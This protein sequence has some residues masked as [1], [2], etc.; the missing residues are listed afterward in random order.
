MQN[1]K[2][3]TGLLL[4]GLWFKCTP[5]TPSSVAIDQTLAKTSRPVVHVGADQLDLL[6][7]KLTGKNIGLV[8]NHTAAVGKTHLTDTLESQGVI[9]KKIFA[10]EHG[11]RGSAADGETIKDGVDIKTGL[12]VISLYGANKKPTREQL[13]DIDVVVFDIQ[14]VGARFYTFISTLH[15]VME[16]CAEQ[17]KK[18]ILLDRPNP[19]GH[20]V[21]GPVLDTALRSFVGMH[22]IPIVHGLTVGE[23]AQM[24]NGE[25]WL[26]KKVVCD[27]EIITVKNWTHQDQY[28]LSIRPSPNLL[29]DQAIALYPSLCWFEG[30]VI[31]VGRGTQIPFL[32]LGNPVLKTL[33]FQFTP[34]DIPGMANNPL[35]KN[36][37][38]YGID[39]RNVPVEPK[40]TLKYLIDF[41]K[42]YPDKEKF[43]LGS[44]DRL[45]GNK[46]LRQQIKDGLSAD[47]IRKTW[48]KDLEKYKAKRLKY[49]L[50]R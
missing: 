10:P 5:R 43:F 7:P 23:L 17:N 13:A 27:V 32:V 44:F 9:I 15:Y 26:T 25:G 16:A 22:P 8:V 31:S 48:Q 37:V 41:Y 14:D 50:Y 24:I 36:Q 47:E 46:L 12:P 21:D 45:A 28:S 29:N 4:L 34:T 49:L 18:L 35:H 11:F 33:P 39:L 3:V 40:V 6:L 19:N 30:T 42:L 38:C 20:Y 1:S 2:I